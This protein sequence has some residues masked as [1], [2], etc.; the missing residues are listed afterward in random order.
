MVDMIVDI[1]PGSCP[2]LGRA[3][4][5]FV[6]LF[7]IC[8]VFEILKVSTIRQELCL[9]VAPIYCNLSGPG[10]RVRL[11]GNYPTGEF[12]HFLLG[13]HSDLAAHKT[14]RFATKLCSKVQFDADVL[15]CLH[16]QALPTE[17]LSTF[18][19]LGRKQA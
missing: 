2:I 1:C 19:V 9:R 13:G 17:L 6:L 4:K 3:G 11:I 16:A 12:D 10:E 18:V 5:T 15:S 14:D 7:K 8:H